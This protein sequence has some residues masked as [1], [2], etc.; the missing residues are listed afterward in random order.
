M[1]PS[2]FPLD[3]RNGIAE[4]LDMP[5]LLSWAKVDTWSFIQSRVTLRRRRRCLI[6]PYCP[7][8]NAFLDALR[9]HDAYI[10]GVHAASFFDYDTKARLDLKMVILVP[11]DAGTDFAT[12][13]GTLA[14]YE[15]VE[16]DPENPDN[17]FRV[18][19]WNAGCRRVMKLKNAL[20]VI[21]LYVS[22][23]ANPWSLLPHMATTFF[24]NIVGADHA[25]CLY[26]A[27]TLNRHSI[28]SPQYKHEGLEDQAVAAL[29]YDGAAGCK[30]YNH[31]REWTSAGPESNAHG[32]TC[33]LR[34]RFV[35]DDYTLALSFSNELND[36]APVA[37]AGLGVRWRKGGIER[38]PLGSVHIAFFSETCPF[39][40][41]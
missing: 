2:I 24:M 1:N 31:Y 26:P 34:K 33:P 9:Q 38:H 3:I 12:A 8:V 13:L 11:A 32:S 36:D 6:E 19:R 15:I 22:T 5:S 10:G 40:F 25:Y 20:H 4:H 37:I 27:V 41:I 14:G 16:D 17:E 7:D 23:N 29:F 35:G 21:Y 18:A 28:L 30:T 39:E